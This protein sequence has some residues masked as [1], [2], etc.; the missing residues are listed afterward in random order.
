M[1]P[2]LHV[3]LYGFRTR[4][5]AQS[6]RYGGYRPQVFFWSH[7][8]LV[9]WLSLGTVG[10]LA[11]HRSGIV[12][13]IVDIP[14][15]WY[16]AALFVTLVLCKQ[17]IAGVL[18]PLAL[19]LHWI[20][21]RTRSYAVLL[22]LMIVIVTLTGMR[23][24]GAW[25]AENL[26]E[27][28]ETL[29][30]ARAQSLETRIVNENALAA[31]AL[32]RP[33]FGWGGF[34]RNRIR[35]EDGED[36]SITDGLWVTHL[37]TYGLVGMTGMLLY[38]AFAVVGFRRAVPTSHW[39]TGPAVGACAVVLWVLLTLVYNVPNSTTNSL[40]LLGIGALTRLPSEDLLDRPD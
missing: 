3:D 2:Q 32:E 22:A 40:V 21:I 37:G 39:M 18:M 24:T 15:K 12:R 38:F 8:P 30:P 9:F 20:V 34:G 5:F 17:F 10:A 6:A 14:L 25:S 31:R 27:F 29:S 28:V 11:F 33:F 26:L 13:K 16:I 35:T 23:A 19:G 1:S 36:E 4:S 7:L